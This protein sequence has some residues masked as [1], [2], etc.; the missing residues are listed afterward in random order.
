[1]S[2]SSWSN[3]RGFSS[4]LA[5][6]RKKVM[7]FWSNCCG[8]PMFAAM[9]VSKGRSLPSPLANFARYSSERTASSPR[10]AYWAARTCGLMLSMLSALRGVEADMVRDETGVL[11]NT[12]DQMCKQQST[13]FKTKYG[14]RLLCK[15]QI[16]LVSPSKVGVK[17]YGVF[18]LQDACPTTTVLGCTTGRR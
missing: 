15:L 9:T 18:F 16:Q 7:G 3:N 2:T 11:I 8:L 12:G 5:T 14:A 13:V 1:M 6:C 17:E 4:R 10:T